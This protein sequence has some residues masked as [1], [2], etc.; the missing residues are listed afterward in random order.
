MACENLHMLCCAS[1]I[2]ILMLFP[3]L[4][5]PKKAKISP[6]LTEKE[7]LSTALKP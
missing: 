3:A 4:F 2:F 1:L 5:S 7:V 6:S